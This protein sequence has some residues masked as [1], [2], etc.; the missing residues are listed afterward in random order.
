M[1]TDRTLIDVVELGFEGWNTRDYDKIASRVTDDYVFETDAVAQPL[2]GREAFLGFVRAF[3]TAFPDLH[4]DLTDVVAAD[5]RVVACWT[6]TGTHLGEF[7]GL[8]PSRRRVRV[9]GVTVTHF[10]DGRIASQRAFWDSASLM[11][12]L[13]G[14]GGDGG[15]EEGGSTDDSP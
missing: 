12:Q 7:R 15:L 11:R 10:R 5:N 9:Q 1:T 13:A 2:R 4:F 8:A 3:L 14:E 6:A